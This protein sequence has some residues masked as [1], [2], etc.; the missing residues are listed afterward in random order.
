[1]QMEMK[2]SIG[3]EMMQLDLPPLNENGKR[4]KVD[5]DDN[6]YKTLVGEKNNRPSQ[7]Q[8]ASRPSQ[9]CGASRTVQPQVPL[10][11]GFNKG[12]EL[13][14]E[15]KTA[16]IVVAALATVN[17]DHYAELVDFWFSEEGKKNME[18]LR[19]SQQSSSKEKP[20]GQLVW[21]KDDIYSQ[22]I[23]KREH[24]G[25][26]RVMGFGYIPTNCGSASNS[27]TRFK[28]TSDEERMQDKETI[29][30]LQEKLEANNQQMEA[31]NQ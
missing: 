15:T 8:G 19:K 28:M 7:T 11:D 20:K 30:E 25:R 12:D 24:S 1:M 5:L 22:V 9:S 16:E 13:D 23:D 4:R 27:G 6:D 29:H 2:T 17:H 26:H 10:R 3:L 14:G 21:C 31:N 18:D